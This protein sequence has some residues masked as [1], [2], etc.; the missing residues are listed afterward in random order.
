MFDWA[1]VI[2]IMLIII[3]EIKMFSNINVHIFKTKKICNCSDEEW[4]EEKNESDD[5]IVNIEEM[6]KKEN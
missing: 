4:S 2:I 6:M 1:L 5:A 3:A